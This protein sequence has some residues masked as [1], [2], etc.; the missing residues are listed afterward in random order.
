M[1]RPNVPLHQALTED[2]LDLHTFFR[3]E[4]S[5]EVS[6]YSLISEDEE[7]PFTPAAAKD[8]L[9]TLAEN[10]KQQAKLQE[11]AAKL[12]GR[13]GIPQ[14][15]A[16][17]VFKQALA[18]KR[19]STAISEELYENCVD[20]TEFHLIMSMGVRVLDEARA[21]RLRKKLKP[22]KGEFKDLNPRTF[23]D[24]SIQFGLA[25]T[26]V[27][28]NYNKAMKYHKLRKCK[29]SK[30][31]DERAEPGEDKEEEIEMSETSEEFSDEEVT[32]QGETTAGAEGEMP[33]LPLVPKLE[34]TEQP[35][36][37]KSE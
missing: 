12:L 14:E 1:I 25:P 21:W 2:E 5:D 23:R 30:K 31:A 27:N 11:D 37:P 26:M 36:P 34:P 4:E 15:A 10:N 8:L 18:V 6:E 9:Y 17:E 35:P 24:L 22:K 3:E 29:K 16:E 33:K 7:D 32:I 13:G 28:Q 20:E 19:K